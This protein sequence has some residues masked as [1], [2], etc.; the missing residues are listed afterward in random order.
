MAQV[1][2]QAR[3]RL[4]QVK[5][6]SH[7]PL[8]TSSMCRMSCRE[9]ATA[10]AE[11][12]PIS[13]IRNPFHM[14]NALPAYA[15]QETALHETHQSQPGQMPQRLWESPQQ[16]PAGLISHRARSSPVKD[17][18]RMARTLPFRSEHALRPKTSARPA[19]N[20][21]ASLVFYR[22]GLIP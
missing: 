3:S 15:L 18:G 11:R 19:A 4:A 16:A 20:S 1:L 9:A 5:E 17:F 14:E 22:C 12:M 6:A 21:A 10:R 2:P 7:F 13:S 8:K